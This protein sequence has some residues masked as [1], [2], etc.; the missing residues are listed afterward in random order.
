MPADT[1]HAL[2]I[3]CSHGDRPAAVVCGHLLRT[4]DRVVGFVENSS[5][6][7]DL[8]AWCDACESAFLREGGLTPQFREFNDMV[9]VCDL[10]YS[11]IKERHNRFPSTGE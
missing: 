2:T 8:Q 11:E 5:D 10:C 3:N 9:V 1:Q 6:P 7:A 4:K